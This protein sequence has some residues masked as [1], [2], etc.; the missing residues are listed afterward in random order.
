MSTVPQ[1]SRAAA[2]VS[3]TDCLV[4]DVR[5]DG[6]GFGPE[7]RGELLGHPVTCIR[8]ELGDQ[9]ARPLPR[10]GPGHGPTDPVTGT[11]DD[12]HP[13]LQSTH[14]SSSEWTVM[15]LGPLLPNPQ[16]PAS[17]ADANAPVVTIR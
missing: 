7:L 16:V 9:D 3:R 12:R 6:Q 2:T 10:E 17:D 1:C 14:H 4:G 11:G 13:I 8:P 5:R 15:R